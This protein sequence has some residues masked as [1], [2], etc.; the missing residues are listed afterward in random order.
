MAARKLPWLEPDDAC[1]LSDDPGP[2]SP[3]ATGD[4]ADAPALVSGVVARV[5][6][7]MAVPVFGEPAGEPN[8]DTDPAPSPGVPSMAGSDLCS[9]MLEPGME[10]IG[11]APTEMAA[12]RLACVEIPPLPSVQGFADLLDDDEAQFESVLSWLDARTRRG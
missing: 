9:E 11:R 5:R 8:A 12:S 2:L 6:S 7:T 3:S 10:P 4:G 1:F